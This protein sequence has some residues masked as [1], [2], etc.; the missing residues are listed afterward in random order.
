MSNLTSAQT[1]KAEDRPISFILE[2]K[3]AI[4]IETVLFIR[5]SDMSRTYPSRM[6]VN[7][8][9]GGAWVDAFGEGLEVTTI[10]GTTG[11]R[12]G[13]D[14]K[15]GTQ[16]IIDMRA[17][18]YI[19]WHSLR[20]AAIARGD[21][22]DDVKL[23]YVDTLNRYSRIIAPQ[24]FE[25]RRNKSSPLLS[26][27]RVS[28]VALAKPIPAAVAAITSGDPSG[29]GASSLLGSIGK[30]AAAI[31]GV[32][33]FVTANILGP[34][35]SFMALT[36]SV[37]DTVHSYINAAK[38]IAGSLIGIARDLAQTGVA[39][40]RTL[41][42]V[43]HLPTDAKNA[44]MQVAGAYSNAFCVLKNSLRPAPTYENYGA[45]HGASNCSSTAGGLPPSL[46]SDKNVF[47]ALT[48]LQSATVSVSRPAR[49]SIDSVKASDVV[50]SPLPIPDLS[51][52]LSNIVVG[53]SVK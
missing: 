30:I 41:A 23:R 1:Q 45:V 34:V 22:P 53:V 11:W 21:N 20:A 43:A 16:R 28:F 37:L 26:T 18:I 15:D 29:F 36:K 32:K 5:P 46:Y 24:V 2:N 6:T 39:L 12:S 10:S 40:F 31:S 8:T 44:L 48:T 25:I 7:Q 13:P 52:A 4:V 51:A 17:Q 19:Q 35:K 9:L 27:Y 49:A 3:G 42:A 14:G 47:A 33:N 38:T 50:N